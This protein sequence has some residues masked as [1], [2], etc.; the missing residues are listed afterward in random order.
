MLAVVERLFEGM[1]AR[2]TTMVRSVLHPEAR[3]LTT[4]ERDGTPFARWVDVD[5]FVG[6][7]ARADRPLDERLFDPEVRIDGSLATVWV[8]Y[9]FYYGDEFSHCGVDAVQ[10]VRTDAGWR[11][12]Q[13]ADTRRRDGCEPSTGR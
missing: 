13:I 10:L 12:M 4:G 8:F 3:L 2:D 11:I 1:R 9:H 6:S 7:I 5:A